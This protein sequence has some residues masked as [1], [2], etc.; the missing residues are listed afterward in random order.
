MLSKPAG[1]GGKGRT[2]KFVCVAADEA[3]DAIGQKALELRR[4]K[5]KGG[6]QDVA[7]MPAPFYETLGA[8]NDSFEIERER[9]EQEAEATALE[10]ALAHM[11]R[12]DDAQRAAL[13]KRFKID[14]PKVER[15]TRGPNKPKPEGTNG[16]GGTEPTATTEDG[17]RD[18]IPFG[19][20]TGATPSMNAPTAPAMTVT[21]PVGTV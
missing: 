4:H 6:W 12:M 14:I 1:A 2:Y 13:E 17:D 18:R 15:K 7:I 10:K 8:Y 19:E 9:L 21:N 5:S 16:D 20:P 3:A 11:G